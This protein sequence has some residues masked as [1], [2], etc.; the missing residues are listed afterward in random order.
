MPRYNS[1]MR[2][3]RGGGAAP[4]ENA[5]FVVPRGNVLPV[6]EIVRNYGSI[7]RTTG[8]GK[9]TNKL[10]DFVRQFVDNRVFDIYL[11]YLGI[12]TLTPG[13]LVPIALIFGQDQ[14]KKAL[15]RMKKTE[16]KGGTIPVLDHALV[17]NFLK[18][19]GLSQLNLSYG[20]LVPLGLAMALYQVF[21]GQKK[22]AASEQK[23]GELS[24]LVSGQHVPPGYLQLGVRYFHGETV[25]NNLGQPISGWEQLTRAAPYVNHELQVP[26]GSPGSCGGVPNAAQFREIRIPNTSLHDPSHSVQ[27]HHS[28]GHSVVSG[29]RT[30]SPVIHDSNGQ[31]YNYNQAYSD[32]TSDNVINQMAGG[33]VKRRGRK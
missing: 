15:K 28:K 21:K 18:L 20:T 30:P 8:G 9:Q 10:W 24:R 4:V 19:A 27:L 3:G 1:T 32:L 23:G 17:G 33:R 16:Q 11:K 26:C 31:S 14:F 12:T 29:I 25:P 13:T 2:H 6:S 5:E 22:E 7:Y